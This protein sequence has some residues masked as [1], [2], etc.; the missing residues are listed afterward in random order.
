MN[1]D[2]QYPISKMPKAIKSKNLVFRVTEEEKNE[3][4]A[5]AQ[6]LNLTVTDYLK[7]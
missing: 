7:R 5:Q 1:I 3:I 4:N 2:S 6:A